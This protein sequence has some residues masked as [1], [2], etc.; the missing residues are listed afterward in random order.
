MP[1]EIPPTNRPVATATKRLEP[2]DLWS[3]RKPLEP[4]SPRGL[5][6][7]S[8]NATYSVVERGTRVV[9][10]DCLTGAPFETLFDLKSCPELDVKT[11][12][13]PTFSRDESKLLIAVRQVK[14]HRSAFTAC[15]FIWDIAQ[16][17]L[18]PLSTREG[19]CLATFSPDG[20]RVAFVSQND[21]FVSEPA[22]GGETR[23]TSDGVLDS[24][25]N[26]RPDWVYA[27]EFGMARAFEWS[28]DGNRIAFLRFDE[29]K[30]PS[31]TLLRHNGGYPEPVSYKYPRAGEA[32]S[33]VSLQMYDLRS[34]TTR[35]LLTTDGDW[36]YIPRIQWTPDGAGLATLRVNRMQNAAE[37]LLFAGDDTAPSTLLLEQDRRYVSAADRLHFLPDGAGFAVVSEA[38]GWRHVHLYDMT[39]KHV[40]QVT[41]GRWDVQTLYGCAESDG[42]LYFCSA[43]PTPL[44]R[45]VWSVAPDGT[46]LQTLSKLPGSNTV[47]FSENMERFVLTHSSAATPPRISIHDASGEETRVLERNTRLRRKLAAY[48]TADREFFTFQNEKSDSLNGWLV[49]PANFES[50][51]KYP[52]LMTVYGGPGSQTVTDSWMFG[53]EQYLAQEGYVVASI[54]GRGTGARGAA[55]RKCTYGRLGKLEVE[56]QAAGARHLAGLPFVDGERIGTFGWSY[57]GFMACGC[58]L[59]APE[60]FRAAI[61]VASVVNFR[62]YDTVYTEK[63]MGTPQ[64]NPRGYDTNAPLTYASNL[65][66]RL[67]LVHGLNDDN[68][69]AQNSFEL[70]EALTKAGKDFETHFVPNRD[71][72]ISGGNT[73]LNLY[74]RMNRFLRE[75]L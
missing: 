36:E 73:R 62:Y 71:H 17:S 51:R 6:L 48:H 21:L 56:D 66:G 52:V 19:Q 18:T 67:L 60:V 41:K 15:H 10:H 30:V 38:S 14:Y 63:L 50:S 43:Q 13:A 11:I 16:R 7:M 75:N 46:G 29:T 40:R 59:R 55:F 58:I 61:A 1:P 54:D 45:T 26:G 32:N 47:A 74:M 20:S 23:I 44:Q 68:V 28:P 42:R 22:K 37:W 65:S 27:E 3:E 12:D 70:V 25:I 57:G 24:I 35:T 53:W 34:G 5:R 69:H 8:A 39:G 64:G 4:K 31:V 33:V 72:G 2:A 9:T 49:K